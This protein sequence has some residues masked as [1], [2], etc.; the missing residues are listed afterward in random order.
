MTAITAMPLRRNGTE[1]EWDE[2]TAG[3]VAPAAAGPDAGEDADH[4]HREPERDKWEV[5]TD[6]PVRMYLAEIGQVALLN[7]AQERDLSRKAETGRYLESLTKASPDKMRA[8]D[9]TLMLIEAAARNAAAAQ[10]AAAIAHAPPQEPEAPEDLPAEELPLDPRLT[11][12]YRASL[13]RLLR[14]E[15]EILPADPLAQDVLDN[16]EV[17]PELRARL[18]EALERPPPPP[19]RDPALSELCADPELRGLLD[20]EPDEET[21][22]ALSART[23]RPPDE[24]KAAI[25]ELSLATRALEQ[26]PVIRALGD[27]PASRLPEALAEAPEKLERLEPLMKAHYRKAITEGEKARKHLAEANLRLV[28]SIA[29]K[30]AGRG[31]ALMDLCQEGNIGL[32][33]AVEKFDYRKGYKFSTYATWWIRQAI[34]RSIADQARTVRIPVH[35]FDA[36][37]KIIRQKRNLV[38]Q[39]GRDP[40]D[41]EVAAAM[42]LPEEKV[43]EALRIA[44]DTISLDTPVSTEQ[45]ASTLGEFIQDDKL[46]QPADAAAK[47]VLKEQVEEVLHTLTEREAKVISLRFGLTDGRTKTLEEVGSVFGVTRERIRQIE[48]KAIRKLRHPSRARILK[49]FLD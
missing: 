22:A 48:A 6:D 7:Q 12:E 5:Q 15:E 49:D 19:D 37:N 27:P 11:P 35:M 41:A 33:R 28:V 14:D 40:S 18:A 8:A 30:N 38:Q 9:I 17:D 4:G 31:M 45:D 36:I 43:E 42:G 32:I 24:V 47:R 34:S 44:L 46:P 29:K 10:A 39:L 23:G 25:L 2:A 21:A 3:P 1:D 16:E 26:E 20:W 13:A